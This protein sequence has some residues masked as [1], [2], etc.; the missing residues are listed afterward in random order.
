MQSISMNLMSLANLHV[1]IFKSMWNHTIGENS[2]WMHCCNTCSINFPLLN[3]LL[4]DFWLF[5][6][7]DLLQDSLHMLLNTWAQSSLLAEMCYYLWWALAS[8]TAF[9]DMMVCACVRFNVGDVT[10]IKKKSG[11]V[12]WN[13]NWKWL[14]LDTDA[15]MANCSCENNCNF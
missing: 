9:C 4:F 14:D 2:Q 11:Q 5:L 8:T 3:R 6:S 12:P 1:E 13:S 10:A 7:T 15:V